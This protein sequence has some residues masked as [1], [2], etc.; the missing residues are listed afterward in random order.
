MKILVIGS[1]GREHALCWKLAQSSRVTK[2]FCAPGNAGIAHVRTKNGVAVELS[3]IKAEDVEGLL[4]LARRERFDLVVVGPEAALCAGLVD[5]MELEH[6]ACFGPQMRGAELEASKIFA[7]SLLRK[8]GIPTADFNVFTDSERA[9]QYVQEHG[10]AM[11]I[12]ADGLCAGKGV[13]M[14]ADSTEAEQAVRRTM[15]DGEFGE[16]GRKISFDAFTGRSGIAPDKEPLGSVR[17]APSL[18]R[19]WLRCVRTEHPRRGATERDDK[20]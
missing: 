10:G 11:V 9:L 4:R 7:K 13:I 12:K 17:M 20:R 14:A 19:P 1:G 3:T 15:I 5:K 18:R 6:M 2:L 16:A 8:H